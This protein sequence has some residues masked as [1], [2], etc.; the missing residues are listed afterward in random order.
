VGNQWVYAGGDETITV[1]VLDETKRIEGVTCIVVHDRVE[2]DGE[3]VEDTDD[4]SG[5]RKDGSVAY[6]GEISREFETFEGDDPQEPELISIEGSWKAGRD[7]D[8]AGTLFLA[9]PAVGETYRQEWSPGNAED[10]ATVVSTSYR[11]GE[12]PALDLHVP[13]ALAQRMC[14]A[15]DCV[16]TR[17]FTPIEPD[18]RELKYYARE[19]GLFLEVDPRSGS[20]VEL[21]ECNVSARCVGLP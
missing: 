4:W 14:G 21:V 7:G 9:E 12:D 6:C 16:V 2:E 3:P 10:A 20:T 5:Q 8:L 15:G 17:E 18:A 11:L 13:R 19:V 1:R